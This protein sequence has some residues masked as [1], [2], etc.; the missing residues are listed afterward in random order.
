MK[1]KKIL[2]LW[3][4]R[5]RRDSWRYKTESSSCQSNIIQCPVSIT[6]VM[7]IISVQTC[8]HIAMWPVLGTRPVQ[9]AGLHAGSEQSSRV[10]QH[11]VDSGVTRSAT[12]EHAV[13]D[14]VQCSTATQPA[15]SARQMPTTCCLLQSTPVNQPVTS[16][17]P[18]SHTYTGLKQLHLNRH[19]T[20]NHLTLSSH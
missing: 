9:A 2:F 16:Q 5:L 1:V 7:S 14:A 3:F 11:R 13:V 17:Q 4:P 18:H 6:D 15:S 8:V 12:S 20:N 19:L 10:R